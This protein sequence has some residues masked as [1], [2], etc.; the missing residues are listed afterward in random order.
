MR[1]GRCSPKSPRPPWTSSDARGGTFPT[2]E[3]RPLAADLG[4]QVLIALLFAGIVAVCFLFVDRP[5]AI[6][7]RG[8][9]PR[10][11]SI[12]EKITF[13]GSVTP[14]LIVLAILYPTLRFSLKRPAAAQRALFVLAAIVVSGLTVDLLKPAVARLRPVEFLSDSAQYGFVFFKA[15]T[16]FNS[17]PSGHATT[18]WAV[19]CALALLQ[20]R[21]R[22]LW[23]GAAATVAASRV[24]IGAHYPGDVI[25]G[26]WFGV[27]IT[28]ALSRSAW[29]RAALATPRGGSPQTAG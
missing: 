20:R 17:F 4:R 5:A 12:F 6:W 26:A 8:L 21:G 2:P 22:L 18:S 9:D 1:A 11:V 10:I 24:I 3:P 16:R 15:G 28:L 14:Y 27:V 23:F 19:A 29:F 7:A 25:A 13:L